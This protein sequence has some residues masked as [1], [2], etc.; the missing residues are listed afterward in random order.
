MEELARGGPAAAKALGMGYTRF[1]EERA[2]GRIKAVRVGSRVLYTQKSLMDY[3]A[4]LE[5]E[6]AAEGA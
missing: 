4:L 2:A 5:E 6:A 1:R 3:V